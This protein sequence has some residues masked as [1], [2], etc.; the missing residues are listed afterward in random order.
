MVKKQRLKKS[1]L[2][3]K[4]VANVQMEDEDVES[5]EENS[6]LDPEDFEY[7]QDSGRSFAF[8]Q[9]ITQE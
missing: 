9:E 1:K 4:V 2:K 8:L 5:A 3:K 6:L 7:F